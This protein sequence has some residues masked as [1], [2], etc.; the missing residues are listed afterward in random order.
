MRGYPRGP[1]VKGDPV[2]ALERLVDDTALSE[3]LLPP[4]PSFQFPIVTGGDLLNV[5][6]AVVT[7]QAAFHAMQEARLERVVRTAINTYAVY[8]SDVGTTGEFRLTMTGNAGS[9]SSDVVPIP[10]GAN[11]VQ[12]LRWLHGYPLWDETDVRVAIEARRTGGAGNLY[13]FPSLG[14]IEQVDPRASTVTAL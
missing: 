8:A 4:I 13:V 12:R 6:L 1:V 11:A 5:F 14:G 3:P 7:T 10:S 9:V 2:R